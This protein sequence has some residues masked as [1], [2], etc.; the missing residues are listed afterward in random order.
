M[1]TA[2]CCVPYFSSS[3]SFWTML[4]VSNLKKNVNNAKPST[5]SIYA[6]TTTLSIAYCPSVLNLCTDFII[7]YGIYKYAAEAVDQITR[8]ITA[9][10]ITN[11]VYAYV[12]SVRFYCSTRYHSCILQFMYELWTLL[13]GNATSFL[14]FFTRNPRIRKAFT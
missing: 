9:A 5:V 2:Y 1:K 7:L 10:I 6:T 11:Q 12:C 4:Q 14:T 3:S 8:W 13:L